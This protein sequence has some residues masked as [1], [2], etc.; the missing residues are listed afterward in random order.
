MRDRVTVGADQLIVQAAV[1]IGVEYQVLLPMPAPFYEK[2]FRDKSVLENFHHYLSK[3]K[4]VSVLSYYEGNCDE[5]I[6]EYGV[7]RD[8]QYR[9][10]GYKLSR[11]CDEIIAIFDGDIENKKL[12]DTTDIIAYRVGLQKTLIHIECKRLL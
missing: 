8:F 11:D 10:A 4:Q 5:N 3:A 7:C 9:A 1:D 6:A 12:G 2:D